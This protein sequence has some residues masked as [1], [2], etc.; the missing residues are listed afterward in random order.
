M[1]HEKPGSKCDRSR[2]E[3]SQKTRIRLAAIVESSDDAIISKDLNG[4]ITS[5]NT[6]AENL[7]GFT[8]EEAVGRSVAMIIPPDRQSEYDRFMRDL[9]QG[10]RVEHHET[11][12][13]TKKGA[14]I[15]VSLTL[16]PI[17]D[18]H[19]RITGASAIARDITARKAAESASG[20]RSSYNRSL[21][22]VSLDPLVTIG[23]DGRIT[24]VNTATESVTGYSR[25]ELVGTDFSNY[26]TE[27]GKAEAG[28][29]QVFDE[30]VVRDYELEIRHRDGHVTPVCYNASVYRDES[31]AVIGVFAAARDITARK[32]AEQKL[33]DSELK[34]RDIFENAVEGIFQTTPKGR[35]LGANPA[36]AKMCGFDTPEDMITM[37]SDVQ[38]DMYVDPADRGRLKKLYEEQ[39]WISAFE[40]RIYRRDRSIRWVSMN[41]RAVRGNDGEVAYYEG[42]VEDITRRKEAEEAVRRS[43]TKFKTLFENANSAIF[44]AKGGVFVDCN[45][46]ALEE[47]QCTRDHIIGQPPHRFS[48]TFQ[49]DGRYSE[50]KAR[51]KMNAALAGDPQFF[52]WKHCRFDGSP[53][54]AEV[55]LN[56]LELDGEMFLQAIVRD[57]TERKRAREAVRTREEELAAIYDNAPV[58]MLLV[59]GQRRVYKVNKYAESF[60]NSSAADLIGRRAGEALGCPYTLD[61]PLGCGFAPSCL[62]CPVRNSIMET[63]ETGR[64]CRQVE[65]TLLHTVG[66]KAREAV[67]LLSTV[68]FSIGEGPSV[69]V[70]LQDITGRKLVEKK[71]ERA[72]RRLKDII[73][74]LPDATV[75]V[76]KKYR[77]VA[78]NRA[79]EEITRLAKRDILTR[80]HYEAATP[81]YGRP[82]PL[83]M[84]LITKES[85]ELEAR[86]DYVK[87]QGNT[88][89]AEVF[90]PALY[91]GSGAH[92]WV[93]ASPLFD[94]KGEFAGIIQGIRDI[95]ERRNA[96]ETLRRAEDKYRGIFENAVE[97]IFQITPDGRLISANPVLAAIFGYDSPRKM[98]HAVTDITSLFYVNPED[99]N[100][101]KGLLDREAVVKRFEV[102]SYRKDGTT[103]WISMSARAVKGPDGE[104]AYYEGTI[105]DITRR[106]EAEDALKESEKRFRELVDQLP[107]TVAETDEEGNFTFVNV[108]GLKRFGYTK[109]DLDRGL[110]IF[111]TIAPEDRGRA[112]EDIQER[113]HGERT[114]G[115]E[116]TFLRKDGTRMPGLVTMKPILRE[117]RLA[118]L[119]SIVIDLT[120]RKQA[121]EKLKEGEKR[122]RTLFESSNDAIILLK[123]DVIVDCNPKALEVHGCT[124]DQLIGETSHR[125]FPPF[126]SDGTGS[127]KSVHGRFRA[128]LTGNP[129]FFEWKHR[130]YDGTFFDAEVSLNAVELGSEPF[131]QVM[132]R[133]ITQRKQM[134]EKLRT[135]S[136]VDELTGLFNRRGFL[137]LSQQ[138]LNRSERAKETMV[139]FF[140]DLDGMKWINDTLGHREGDTALVGVADVLRETFRKSDVIGRVGGDEFAILAISGADGDREALARLDHCLDARNSTGT[141]R[142]RLSLS[143][144]FA[145]FDPYAPTSLDELISR[146]DILMYEEKRKKQPPLRE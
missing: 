11:E 129:Q 19:G 140:I 123:G 39:G 78:W 112:E 116:Y 75:V 63:M 59:D 37:V 137:T 58:I 130:R 30:G 6:G 98:I 10:I 115:V 47:F 36:L 23:P 146:A 114:G 89:Y 13:L 52:E 94:D 144:G 4:T 53:F 142:Y 66:G 80:D 121:E 77:I 64:P 86:Y 133:D 120:E 49:P 67:A 88:L 41:G 24:D 40:A 3:G 127:K 45:S 91:N 145:H 60:L 118:G 43:E 2:H 27:P 122:Y 8:A 111:Q 119:R 34:Y 83:I 126:H 65:V 33:R 1:L 15:S 38:K 55:S 12:R 135:M 56:A 108:M 74:F 76:D 28:Y 132:V 106:K 124:R 44:V 109:D 20:K 128:V 42:T 81:F 139:L 141:A 5:W 17:R 110:N 93:T 82:G 85:A 16:S 71:L 32:V 104:T 61:D 100:A 31:G 92:M 51:D 95:T 136:V 105:E 22:E 35:I 70:T 14:K 107:E 72:N 57:I 134:E 48:P 54:D 62:K 138:Q 73:E 103:A 99:H 97:G 96:E 9:K 68:R 131:I 21:I 7:Y 18:D 87:R 84:D 125:F 143:V 26:F 102:R 117:K 50:E 101:L 25:D 90:T 46:R 79:M 29:Q 113:L 69:L